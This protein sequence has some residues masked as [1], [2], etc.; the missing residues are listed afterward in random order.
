MAYPDLRH[1]YFLDIT[2]LYQRDKNRP[3]F[4]K[5]KKKTN[6]RGKKKKD[7]RL[8]FSVYIMSREVHSLFYVLS[9]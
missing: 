6:A 1:F 8:L 2:A 7:T 5:S 3:C 9:A 4:L